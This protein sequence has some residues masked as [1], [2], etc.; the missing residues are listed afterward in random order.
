MGM[1]GCPDCL[2]LEAENVALRRRVAE[3]E[4]RDAEKDAR[5]ADLQSAVRKIAARAGLN[6][7]NSSM[8]PSS[9]LARGKKP[10]PREREE[11]GEK[12]PRGGQPG[13]KGA[14]RKPFPDAEV[15]KIVPLLPEACDGCGGKL[16]G[17]GTLAGTHQVVDVKPEPVDVTEYRMFARTCRC[18]VTTVAKLPASVSPWCLGFR[19]QAVLTTLTGRFRISRRGG[20]SNRRA[21][22]A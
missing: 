15:D 4:R 1:Q 5:I 16:H 2:R 14:T 20:G 22:R 19:L 12:R 3:L 7:T 8:P 17:Q 9:D 21:G 13:H 6:S 10:P 18:G 11:R